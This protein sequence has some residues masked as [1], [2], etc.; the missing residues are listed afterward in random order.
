VGQPV[1][2]RARHPV[3]PV[4]LRL[5]HSLQAPQPLLAL[6]T[7]DHQQWQA[8]PQGWRFEPVCFADT[9]RLQRQQQGPRGQEQ[10]WC[11]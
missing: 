3:H 11:S 9:N 5:G 6:L 4:W 10:F 2:H 8:H 1:D 7:R